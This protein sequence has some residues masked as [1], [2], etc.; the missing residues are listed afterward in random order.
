MNSVNLLAHKIQLQAPRVSLHELY[1]HKQI[2][3]LPRSMEYS[4]AHVEGGQRLFEQ[5]PRL[6]Q[7]VLEPA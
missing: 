6:Q 1:H 5:L 3:I 4:I 2:E 7:L